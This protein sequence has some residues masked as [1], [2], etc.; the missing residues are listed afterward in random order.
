VRFA[1]V[2]EFGLSSGDG[3]VEMVARLVRPIAPLYVV[4]VATPLHR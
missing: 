1:I 4:R 2:E 3:E